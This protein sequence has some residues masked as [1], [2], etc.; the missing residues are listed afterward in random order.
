[1][2][3]FKPEFVKIIKEGKKTQTRRKWKKC[4]IKAGDI[5]ELKTRPID[6]AFAKAKIIRVYRQKLIDM[7]FNEIRKEG[8][9]NREKFIECWLKIYGNWIPNE[10]VYVIEFKVIE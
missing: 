1:L 10:E 3:L 5:Q 9:E 6:K 2:I 8:F 7:S 4:H